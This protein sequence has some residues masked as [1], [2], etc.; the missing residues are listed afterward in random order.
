MTSTADDIGAPAEQQGAG[1]DRRLQGGAWRRVLQGSGSAPTARRITLLRAPASSTSFDQP[2]TP[3]TFTDTVTN[4]ARRRRRSRSRPVRW[5]RTTSSRT[6]VTL[7]DSASQHITDFQ[8]ITTT[9]R[10]SPS[11]SRRAEP[12]QRVDRLPERVALRSERTR[13]DD[14]GRPVRRAGR[15]PRPQGDGDYGDVQITDP[16]PGTWTAYI[17][18]RD[19]AT[20]G[21]RA[22]CSSR[23]ASRGTTRSGARPRPTL[24]LAPGQSG[25]FTLRVGR[26]RS[27]VTR[28][29]RSC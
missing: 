29:A 4:T 23:P 6:T 13:P 15:L 9:T 24:T 20:E 12:A 10:R 28:P 14:A 11:T 25:A 3:E 2:G 22:R 17:Y 19:T 7:S 21:P 27:L 16:E 8:G 18:S 5:A 1:P 26:R